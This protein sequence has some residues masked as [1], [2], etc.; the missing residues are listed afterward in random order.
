MIHEI[1]LEADPDAVWQAITDPD[2]LAGWM[3]GPVDLTVAPGAVGSIVDDTGTRYEVLVTE[4]DERCRVAWHWWDERGELSSVEIT[5][6]QVGNAT[7]VR[8]VEMPV[9]PVASG[10]ASARASC[11]RRWA[12]ATERIWSRVAVHA[13]AW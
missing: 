9:G 5:I 6:R 11:A 8:V 4:V 2:E 13:G 7:R 12:R 3:G 10:A 1:D